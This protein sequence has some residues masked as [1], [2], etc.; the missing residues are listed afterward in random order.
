GELA[1]PALRAQALT[2]SLVETGSLSGA[3]RIP[4]A[5]G[6]LLVTVGLR[7]AKV[8]CYV[9]VDAPREGRSTTR[10]NWLIRHLRTAPESIRIEAFTMH[11][12]GGGA[13][14]LL[15]NVRENPAL[16]VS[17]PTREMRAFRV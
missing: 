1:E 16:L 2:A 13:A 7:A 14:E 10:V 4:G 11:S 8:T 3:I 15:G 6:P 12:R 17:D 5:V 9:D